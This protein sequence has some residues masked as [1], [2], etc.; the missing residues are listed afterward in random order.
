MDVAGSVLDPELGDHVCLPFAGEGERIA[1]T[2]LFTANGLRRG[3]RV[4]IVTC[5]R[6]PEETRA[7]LAPAVPGLAR[8]EAEGRVVIRPAGA[9]T[10]TAGRPDPG[11]VLKGL[12]AAVERAGQDGH[13]GL[14]AL[15][16]AAWG[17]GDPARQTTCEAVSNPLFGERRLASVCQ[18]D[19]RLFS[20]EAVERAASVHP[21]APERAALRYAATSRPPGLRLSGD[22]DLTNRQALASVLAPL[23]R[24]PGEVVVDLTALGFIDA[25]SAQL[26]S[27][28]ALA[29]QGRPTVVVCGEAVARVLRL[30]RADAL[31]TVRRGDGG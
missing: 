13:A 4:L 17:A 14:Y 12:S 9:T 5:A 24:E 19:L 25:G 31:L 6:T 29:R 15:V 30:V 18:Y 11:R 16:D 22:V 20:G 3:A 28:T 26:L 10:L 1:A 8:A 21:I 2:R 27:A 23:E 7:W